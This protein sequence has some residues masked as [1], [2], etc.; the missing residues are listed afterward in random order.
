MKILF[1]WQHL[2]DA[3]RQ[4]GVV[5]APG[6]TK[7]EIARAETTYGFHFP[8]DLCQFLQCA[9][10]VDTPP[11]PAGVIRHSRSRFPNWRKDSEDFIRERLS[12]P[13]EGI[14]FDIE[15]NGVWRQS[16]GPRPDALQDALRVARE[17]IAAAPT[18]IP[19]Y[20]HRYMPAEPHEAG[21]PVFSVY[22]TDIIYY[23]CDLAHYLAHEFGCACPTWAATQPRPIEF[24]D[25]FL[26]E[27]YD[28]NSHLVGGGR[29]LTGL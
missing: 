7:A 14:C 18:L 20:G 1:P 24:W 28:E 11:P 27:M 19:I 13:T 2:I 3:L 23:G 5:F 22:Q 29:L 10:P 17:A 9:L 25:W 16:W 4:H 8:P 21:N 15:H 12:W 26:L 6:L